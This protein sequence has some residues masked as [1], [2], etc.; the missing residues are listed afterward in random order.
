MAKL[1]YCFVINVLYGFFHHKKRMVYFGIKNECFMK[2]Q[3]FYK[4]MSLKAQKNEREDALS[5]PYRK[6][7]CCPNL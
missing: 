1:V 5:L 7:V 3:A 2:I 6:L 4:I